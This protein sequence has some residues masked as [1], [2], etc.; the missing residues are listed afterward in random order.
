MAKN[1]LEKIA[2]AEAEIR[3]LNERVKILTRKSDYIHIK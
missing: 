3:Q 2:E 1:N